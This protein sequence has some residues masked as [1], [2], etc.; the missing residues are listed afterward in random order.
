MKKRIILVLCV[1][2][3]MTACLLPLSGCGKGSGD[4]A[5]QTGG[6]EATRK[7]NNG[8]AET[9]PEHDFGG[10]T[11]YIYNSINAVYSWGTS[12][13]YIQGSDEDTTSVS[14]FVLARNS[15]IVENMNADFQY[16]NVTENYANVAEYY[17]RIIMSG[18]PMDL[19]IN[20]LFPL[21][22]LSLEGYFTNVANNNYF[23]Y[24]SD[25][26]Y[27]DYM[28]DLSLDGNTGYILAGD[29][30]MDIIR[31]VN[32]LAY[33]MDLMDQIYSANG[34]NTG[35]VEM[36]QDGDWT[37]EEMIQ[38]SN[39]AYLDNNGNGEHDDDDRYGYVSTQIWGA[40]IPMVSGFD[41]EYISVEDGEATV[42]LNNDRSSQALD[43][44]KALFLGDGTPGY[45]M[46]SGDAKLKTL[47]PDAVFTSGRALFLGEKRFASMATFTDMTARW[48]VVIYPK[49]NTSQT[50]YIS[51]THDT[52]EVGAIPRLCSD[53]DSVLQLLEYMSMLTNRS[54][55]H[56]YYDT[57]LKSR[58]SKE[59]I[60]ADMVDLIH[61][62]LGGSFVVGYN[63]AF[64][65][66]FMWEPF[67]KALLNDRNF[68]AYYPTYSTQLAGK[69]D[70]VMKNWQKFLE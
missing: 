6:E 28:N 51:P 68:A 62:N 18:E 8:E 9:M 25:Y 64:G 65:D 2:L 11:F 32:V 56:E 67:Y 17:R 58:Y 27:T 53:K 45:D 54:V 21:V 33:N 31:S 10:K 46:E 23:D 36:V 20:K 47:S 37:I 19:F 49:L 30:F 70:S 15:Y 34:G 5:K 16:I 40:L 35:F 63:N 57:L 61:E 55:M 43:H 39:S 13:I 44:M 3:C 69:A 26:W 50:G 38:L 48:G 59:P 1:L 60:V 7:P 24:Y 4:P 52:T 42:T 14:Q 66:Y 22:N 29:Y 41:L 12:N